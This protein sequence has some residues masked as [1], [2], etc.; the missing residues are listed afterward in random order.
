MYKVSGGTRNVG[1]CKVDGKREFC[2]KQWPEAPGLEI[3]SNLLYK[4]I[5]AQCIDVHG[6]KHHTFN[7]TQTRTQVIVMNEMVFSVS[8]YVEGENLAKWMRREGDVLKQNTNPRQIR[9]MILWSLLVCPEDCRRANCIMRYVGKTA[10]KDDFQVVSIDN[11]RAFGPR[12]R[13]QEEVVIRSHS[14]FFSFPQMNEKCRRDGDGHKT[15]DGIANSVM[16]Q[17]TDDNLEKWFNELRTEHQ[18]QV[19]LRG[20]VDIKRRT[21]K[22]TI[23]GVPITKKLFKEFYDRVRVIRDGVSEGSTKTY[24][25]LLGQTDR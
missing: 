10:G 25:D 11:D 2:F 12:A 3:A 13:L 19:A 23:L 20:Y 18:Y 24:M 16:K 8:S 21:I 22:K 14:L 6:S 4:T 9:A 7:G 5:F 1:I 17:L 15:H